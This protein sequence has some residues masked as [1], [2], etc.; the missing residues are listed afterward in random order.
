MVKNKTE[1]IRI[2]ILLTLYISVLNNT[3]AQK[4]KRLFPATIQEAYDTV[5]DE[6]HDSEEDKHQ[7]YGIV[8]RNYCRIT[9]VL[10]ETDRSL[11]FSKIRTYS[12]NRDTFYNFFLYNSVHCFFPE[13]Y[14]SCR[15]DL[16]RKLTLKSYKAYDLIGLFQLYSFRDSIRKSLSG[17]WF[18]EVEENLYPTFTLSKKTLQKG[19]GYITLANLG[20]KDIE[21]KIIDLFLNYTLTLDLNSKKKKKVL[22]QGSFYELVVQHIFRKLLSKE[23]LKKTSVLLDNHNNSRQ[24]SHGYHGVPHL[25]LYFSSV[26]K[27]K[28]HPIYRNSFEMCNA[29]LLTEDDSELLKSRVHS[30]RKAIITDDPT[31]LLESSSYQFCYDSFMRFHKDS[32]AWSNI[33]ELWN[34]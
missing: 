26:F 3:V 1:M 8:A 11:L 13:E 34:Q 31:I 25:G 12:S 32:V 27:E 14:N 23:S 24:Y 2:I 17:N 20:D 21:K 4:S 16:E 22:K 19:V 10:E 30:I 7:A 18:K 28:L 6:T 9:V 29:H 15:K 33:Y 5:K